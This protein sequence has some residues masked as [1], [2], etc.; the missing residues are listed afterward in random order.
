[1]KKWILALFVVVAFIASLPAQSSS[2][3]TQ[4]IAIVGVT[5]VISGKLPATT[6]IDVNLTQTPLGSI[7]INA[8]VGGSW[9]LT[10]HSANGGKMIGVATKSEYPYTVSIAS[11]D[12]RS[13]SA[14]RS[15][16][17]TGSGMKNYPLTAHY[18]PA[19]TL[20]LAADTYKDT[21]TITVTKI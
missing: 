21:I 19:A 4:I 14:D 6:I 9:T 18:S 8:N 5:D 7:S 20:G 17:V 15:I 11:I 3:S 13:L 1:M 2:S 10:L 16:T 12:K